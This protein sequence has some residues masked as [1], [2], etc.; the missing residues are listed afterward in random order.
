VSGFAASVVGLTVLCD[1]TKFVASSSN[2]MILDCVI[3]VGD[4]TVAAAD[5]MLVP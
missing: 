2:K 1:C 3:P 5:D 4:H